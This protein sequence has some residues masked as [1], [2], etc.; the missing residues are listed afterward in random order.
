MILSFVMLS[1][2][3]NKVHVCSTR[4]RCF[5]ATHGAHSAFLN[6]VFFSLFFSLF[7]SSL[8]S[9]F[10]VSTM[11]GAKDKGKKGKRL[12]QGREERKGLHNSV[13]RKGGKGSKLFLLKVDFSRFSSLLLRLSF[14]TSF[15]LLL[16]Q[17]RQQCVVKRKT[18]KGFYK[19]TLT[20]FP[21]ISHISA[22]GLQRWIYIFF[23]GT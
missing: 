14:K 19:V 9:S 18:T 6:K 12:E 4:C 22:W 8:S 13:K 15:F 2:K 20:F 10:L 7:S 21:Y 1:R 5:R 11:H 16:L 23:S 3:K 17:P